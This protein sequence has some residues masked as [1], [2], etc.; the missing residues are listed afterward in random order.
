MW[1]T[2]Q[3]IFDMDT[4]LSAPSAPS[5]PAVLEPEQDAARDSDSSSEYSYNDNDCEICI[6][7]IVLP[8]ELAC[9]HTFCRTC[10]TKWANICA[11]HQQAEEPPLAPQAMTMTC[12]KCRCMTLPPKRMTVVNK[13]VHYLAAD[14]PWLEYEPTMTVGEVLLGLAAGTGSVAILEW[15]VLVKGVDPLQVLFPRG[16][17]VM[18][19]AAMR[20]NMFS[21]KT[22][23]ALDFQALAHQP[24]SEGKTP[25]DELLSD[26]SMENADAVL[27]VLAQ[28]SLLP[29]GWEERAAQSS[30]TGIAT[31]G[32]DVRWHGK[33]Y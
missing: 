32:N 7:P 18:H 21:V 1:L 9:G 31:Y 5:V 8:E 25:V 14:S 33:A 27:D 17:N 29:A 12:P 15:L 4:R 16:R 23:I 11:Q 22:L 28:C 6:R 24:S 26:C 19:I 10:L 3:G 2:D 30:S 13:L 20:G